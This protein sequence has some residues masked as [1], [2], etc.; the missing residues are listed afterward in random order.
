MRKAI[1]FLAIIAVFIATIGYCSDNDQ[2]LYLDNIYGVYGIKCSLNTIA[3]VFP[4][5]DSNHIRVR[6]SYIGQDDDWVDIKDILI[7][8]R[9]GNVVKCHKDVT[10][11]DFA[12]IRDLIFEN[13][14]FDI[15]F[16]N[17]EIFLHFDKP[18]FPDDFF[19]REGLTK[20]C[21]SIFLRKYCKALSEDAKDFCFKQIVQNNYRYI[22]QDVFEVLSNTENY[23]TLRMVAYSYNSVYEGDFY[24]DH[25]YYTFN[26]KTN[27]LVT[28]DSLINNSICK[29]KLVNYIKTEFERRVDNCFNEKGEDFER[30]SDYGGPSIDTLLYLSG[31]N[32]QKW[33]FDNCLMQGLIIDENEKKVKIIFYDDAPDDIPLG[34]RTLFCIDVPFSMFS[35]IE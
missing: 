32:G 6:I 14:H 21:Q 2:Y 9:K 24:L 20:D 35:N 4:G 7:A 22:N 31:Q 12:S 18:F 28:L 33:S 29:E 17:N 15:K 1:V 34:Y 3:I 5:K 8:S 27:Q 19:E 23:I 10:K 11:N 13:N 16:E 30:W 25:N 26:K